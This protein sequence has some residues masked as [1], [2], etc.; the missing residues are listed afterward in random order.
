[1]QVAVILRTQLPCRARTP[2]SSSG[3][4]KC[5]PRHVRKGTI[6]ST[7]LRAEGIVHMEPMNWSDLPE[8]ARLF[9]QAIRSPTG[10]R[11]VLEE[12]VFVE[13]IETKCSFIASHLKP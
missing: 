10:E 1:M 6:N 8:Q 2:H 12:N 9:F 11:M 4:P 3:R 5:C 13:K 7:L